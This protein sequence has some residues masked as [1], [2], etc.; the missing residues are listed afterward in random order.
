MPGRSESIAA[1]TPSTFLQS[2]LSREALATPPSCGVKRRTR[3]TEAK[4]YRPQEVR[5]ETDDAGS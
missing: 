2:A 5:P 3:A 1:L 4:R